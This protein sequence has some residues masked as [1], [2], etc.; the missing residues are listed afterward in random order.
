MNQPRRIPELP[1][2]SSHYYRIIDALGSTRVSRRSLLIGLAASPSLLPLVGYAAR[3]ASNFTVRHDQRSIEI[4]ISGVEA[5]R[6]DTSWFD[7]DPKLDVDY[8]QDFLSVDL[9]NAYFPGTDISAL[10]SLRARRI[11]M[12][13]EGELQLPA[14][15]FRARMRF[16]EWLLGLEPAKGTFSLPIA[17]FRAMQGV[18]LSGLS[19]EL[20]FRPDWLIWAERLDGGRMNISSQSLNLS[21]WAMQLPDATPGLS[22]L[23]RRSWLFVPIDGYQT[24]PF[25]SEG[26]VLELRGKVNGFIDTGKTD[27]QWLIHSECKT[28]GV[29][30]WQGECC[31]DVHV[32]S[33]IVTR[34]FSAQGEV[35]IAE[36]IPVEDWVRFDRGAVQLRDFTN[37]QIVITHESSG[38]ST[39]TRT[40]PFP[41]VNRFVVALQGS[42]QAIFESRVN[43]PKDV[44]AL[45]PAKLTDFAKHDIPLDAYDLILR[46]SVDGLYCRV[47]FR[48]LRLRQN[49]RGWYLYA[50]ADKESMLEFD[51]GSQHLR[52]EA[53]YFTDWCKK[54]SC[55]GSD[56][57]PASDE[58]AALTLIQLIKDKNHIAA[59]ANFIQLLSSEDKPNQ[60]ITQKPIEQF[61]ALLKSDK[62]RDNY[63]KFRKDPISKGRHGEGIAASI[64]MR[65][66]AAGASHLTFS[67]SKGEKLLLNMDALFSWAAASKSN[68]GTKLKA[69]FSKRAAQRGVPSLEDATLNEVVIDPASLAK[70]QPA[71]DKKDPSYTYHEYATRI[72]APAHLVVSPIPA[73][74]GSK[75]GSNPQW[76]SPSP[77]LV[78]TADSNARAELWSARLSS[79]EL[80]A[81]Y[82]SR[83]TFESPSTSKGR[84][85]GGKVKMFSPPPPYPFS[86][87]GR[88]VKDFR[89]S[90]DSRDLHEL[91]CLTAV[92]NAPALCGSKQVQG[93]NSNDGGPTVPSYDLGSN[94]S[95]GV[96][97]PE[98]MRAELLMLTSQGA[99]FRYRGTWS[100]P[101]SSESEG[102]LT[103][104]RYN[105]DAHL[106]RDSEVRFEYKGFLFP[107]GQ[108]ATLVKETQRKFSLEKDKWVAR[109][110]QRFYIHVPAFK[111][112]FKAVGQVHDRLWGHAETGMKSFTTPDLD[113]PES[114]QFLE[115]LGS[116]VFWP[117]VP[118]NGGDSEDVIFEFED[119]L[120]STTYAAP[121]VFV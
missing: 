9:S 58:V 111:R 7:G 99:T 11:G 46:R 90:Y 69:V 114:S 83:M 27:A 74:D 108:P 50:T 5:W 97:I 55:E 101:A 63:K 88:E 8:T 121:L 62:Y 1:E 14:L 115:S 26:P 17:S 18:A 23:P 82:S 87:T 33:A 47:R 64:G 37:P 25:G 56:D 79:V 105:H 109:L 70:P 112:S 48:K 104:K 21:A 117:R 36:V 103:L 51:F 96:F 29:L 98:P 72:E 110:V 44:T 42:D 92:Y 19:G 68:D 85:L 60:P 30:S 84:V 38:A 73:R 31:L 116:S 89:A 59:H 22:Q 106:G 120:T 16:A 24:I 94:P 54:P 95:T 66:E 45:T 4:D 28:V 32:Q 86:P 77:A 3:A 100:P 80:R 35:R 49:Q 40:S 71:I 119:T 43:N 13:W 12:D 81:L 41:F 53:M 10:L 2:A 76:K 93:C 113:K 57:F 34:I 91:V 67:L 6:L 65:S 107:L 78:G 118:R 20:Q 75:D 61:I 102:A 15:E 39:Y 52:E